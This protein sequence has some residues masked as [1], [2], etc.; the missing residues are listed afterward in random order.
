VRILAALGAVVAASS[1]LAAPAISIDDVAGVYKH[2]FQNGMVD[3][4]KYA[5]EDIL[6]IVRVSPT[7]AYVRVH[8]EFYNGHLCSISG[9]A[10]AEGDALVYRPHQDYGEQ[11]ALRLQEQKGSLVFADPGGSCKVQYCGMRGSFRG[12][13]FSLKDRR[14][15]RYM[16]VLLNSR[17][18]G[19]AVAERDGKK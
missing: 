14:A 12:E 8:L 11:C 13:A 16:R 1:A 2:R 9:I 15:I 17:E 3:G 7:E 10:K 19:Q 4:T 18:Y 5:S 6:E